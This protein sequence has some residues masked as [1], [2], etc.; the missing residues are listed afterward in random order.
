VK[1]NLFRSLNAFL[2]IGRTGKSDRQ[3]IFI[4]AK[5]M[6]NFRQRY[7]SLKGVDMN[8]TAWTPPDLLQM[9]GSYWSACTLHSGVKLDLF[10]QLDET[11]ATAPELA[12][13]T[14]LS[15]R[16]LTMQ[17]DAL[18][19]LDLLQKKDGVY[20]TTPFSARFLSKRSPDYMGHIISHHHHLVEG[21]SRLDESV[22]TGE[23][24]RNRVSHEPSAI[25]RE[26]FLMGMFN[27]AM[28][29]APKIVPQVDLSGRRHL[30]DL[31]G[32]PGTYAI[33]FCMHNPELKATIF[34]LPE[35]REFAEKTAAKFSM[36]GRI[37]FQSGDFQSDQIEGSYEVA[38]LSHVLHGEGESGCA[39]MLQKAVAALEPGGLLLV[40]E[41]I[42]ENDRARPVFPALFSL[43]MLLGTP[44]GKAYSESELMVLLQNAGLEKVERLPLDLPNG[45]GLICGRRP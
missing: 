45:S 12:G 14:G 3:N 17:L 2:G 4:S 41:F 32:G 38:W 19:A 5:M 43:N 11:P 23:P 42:L 21:W 28:L 40:H 8:E 29:V 36:Q 25:E 18:T 16:G 20:H 39:N 44:S 13:R 33:H 35:S 34:D 27:L 37:D 30:L 22:Q 7:S 9:S 10:T 26:S 15:E 6:V 1:P 24:V 31:G